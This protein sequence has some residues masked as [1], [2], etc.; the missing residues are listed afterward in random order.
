V[1]GI[2]IGPGLYKLF[3]MKTGA[4]CELDLSGFKTEL[5]AVEHLVRCA[6]VYEDTPARR[7]AFLDA[8]AGAVQH[9]EDDG[10][11]PPFC[12][13]CGQEIDPETCGCG[14]AMPCYEHGI[15]MGCS[16]LRVDHGD[17]AIAKGLRERLRAERA[18]RGTP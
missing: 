6:M 2:S 12:D 17:G 5:E 10:P 8:V 4:R 16:C 11:L 18:A 13:G 7:R 14:S 1:S 3:I 15:P 9:M